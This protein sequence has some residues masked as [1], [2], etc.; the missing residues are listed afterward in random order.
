MFC[1]FEKRGVYLAE[2]PPADNVLFEENPL[3]IISPEYS[4]PA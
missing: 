2:V 4:R 3:G 1:C